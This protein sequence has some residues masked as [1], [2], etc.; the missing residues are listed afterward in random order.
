MA[1]RGRP[2]TS[3]FSRVEQLQRA[4]RKQ[5]ARQQHAG[6]VHVQ[7]TLPEQ[8]AAKLTVAKRSAEF[9]EFLDAALDRV[10]IRIADYPALADLAWNRTEPLIPAR[11]ALNLY[12]RN[13]RF[14]DQAGLSANERE[15]IG[16][17]VGKYGG[18][19]IHA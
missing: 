3:K 17:L 15:L 11:E 13:W 10:V 4:K 9:L 5:R 12:E 7:M 14:V 1:T 19:V 8:L 2:K 16:Q 6:L 18:G